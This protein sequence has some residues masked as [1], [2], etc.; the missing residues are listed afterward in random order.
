MP[1]TPESM[2]KEEALKT[3]EFE[4]QVDE[5]FEKD[6]D[7]VIENIIKTRIIEHTS[8]TNDDI[9]KQISWGI[10]TYF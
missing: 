7:S 1:I 6:R 8:A 3:K 10:F 4:K 5:A 2:K 9:E